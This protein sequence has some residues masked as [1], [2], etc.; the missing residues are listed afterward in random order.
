MK[1]HGYL[2]LFLLAGLGSVGI[3]LPVSAQSLPCGQESAKHSAASYAA[4]VYVPL[5]DVAYTFLNALAARGA[6]NAL[7]A[8]ERPYTVGAIRRAV[9]ASRADTSHN[10][11]HGRVA[12]G[13]YRSLLASIAKYDVR[14]DAR[15]DDDVLAARADTSTETVSGTSC[16][17]DT[18]AFHVR[19]NA[20]VY[21]TGETSGRRELML[22]DSTRGLYPGA[23]IR[24]MMHAGPVVA[25]LRP[26]ID[27]RLNHDP[28]FPGR[29]D[30]KIAGRMEDGYASGQWKYG[31]LFLGRMGRNWGPYT[32]VGLQL[33]NYAYTYDQLAGRIGT[34]RFHLS[35]VLA[36]LD[37]YLDMPGSPS[38]RDFQRYFT[39]HRLAA[40]LGG[41]GRFETAISEA[42]VYGGPGRG[43]EFNLSN[44]FNIG[45]LSYRN[46]GAEANFN[47]GWEA[48]WHSVRHGIYS[49]HL[50]VD[51]YQ[52]DRG[53]SPI[54]RKPSSTGLTLT[55]EGVPVGL[56][57]LGDARGFAS[58]TRISNL[59][60]NN[61][62]PYE[63][64][65]VYGVSLGR[66]FSDYDEARIGLDLAV[67]PTAPLRLYAAHRR[68]GEGDYRLPHPDPS[69][70]NAVPE[71]L[72]GVVMTVNRIGLSGATTAPFMGSDVQV[73][74]DIGVNRTQNAN[75]VVG[76][77]RN[78]VEGRVRLAW[79]P[80][81]SIAF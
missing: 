34:E 1:S 14:A 37:T 63:H 9:G 16:D 62:T 76:V 10:V 70:Y 74:G 39:I 30:R 3:P 46:E 55:A 15:A 59:T 11:P 50:M 56:S 28:E 23:D 68:Q 8:L 32:D 54:C 36:K 51:D 6:L 26:I 42:S 69:T 77:Q 5:D 18:S 40:R 21:V 24:I 72:S 17:A 49:A 12:D 48:A 79:V 44:P 35:S 13:L 73:S 66:G 60:Y 4:S 81:F 75:H 27:N 80:H 29:K 64:Y 71:F 58:Y 31:E 47:L 22:A 20:D 38:E 7:S 52:I 43:I 78:D 67:I 19:A 53:C 2:L 65:T 33:G 25:V 41:H 57:L 45:L 61:L